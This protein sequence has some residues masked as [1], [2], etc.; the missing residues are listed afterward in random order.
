MAELYSIVNRNIDKA[1]N[2]VNAEINLNIDHNIF[3]GH[4]P[5]QPVLPGVC[6]VE[7]IEQILSSELGSQL[8]L[9][10]A[11]NIKYLKMVDPKIDARLNVDISFQKIEEGLKV[12]A[13]IK[14]KEEIC[15]KAKL[16]FAII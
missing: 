6:Q 14:S 5:T 16:N 10:A 7:I 8:R 11:S 13:V 1:L 9:T 4:F 12:T 3:K 15:M 2:K